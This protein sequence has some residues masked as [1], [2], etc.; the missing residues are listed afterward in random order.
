MAAFTEKAVAKIAEQRQHLQEKEDAAQRRWGANWTTESL[1][2]FRKTFGAD[3][4]TIHEES[5]AESEAS[6]TIIGRKESHEGPAEADAGGDAVDALPA[7]EVPGVSHV[8]IEMSLDDLPGAGAAIVPYG[9]DPSLF[10]EN[11]AS[12]SVR[13]LPRPMG[14]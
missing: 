8:D 14:R 7:K 2:D 1:A 9:T 3:V 13:N 5:E 10:A 6:T 11:A 12:S 4:F